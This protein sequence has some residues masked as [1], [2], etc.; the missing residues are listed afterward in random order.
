MSRKIK[1]ITLSADEHVI[2]LA[3]DRARM[4]KRSLNDAFREWLEQF[5]RIQTTA[6]EYTE[7]MNKLSHIQVGRRFSRDE[8]N[9]R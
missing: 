7:L 2:K 6:V 8:M 3:R 1:N 4:Q 5:S 9:E